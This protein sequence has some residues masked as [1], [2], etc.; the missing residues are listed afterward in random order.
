[1]MIKNYL[2]K[3]GKIKAWPAKTEAKHAV[4]AYMSTKFELGRDYKEKEVNAIIEANHAFGDY[5]LLRRGMVDLGV[6]ART[7]DG[8]RYWRVLPE[9]ENKMVSSDYIEI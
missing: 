4:L 9:E 7:P 6:M 8:A 2:N 3:D 1:M 5:F